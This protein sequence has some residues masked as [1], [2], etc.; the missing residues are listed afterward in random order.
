MGSK[1][2]LFVLAAVIT[3]VWPF[4]LVRSVWGPRPPPSMLLTPLRSLRSDSHSTKSPVASR[5]AR[6]GTRNLLE[7]R[8]WGRET[9]FKEET[10]RP[11]ALDCN[12]LISP[13]S[14]RKT[15]GGAGG[16]VGRE[17]AGVAGRR[18]AWVGD[19]PAGF[20]SPLAPRGCCL[21]SPPRGPAPSP[22]PPDQPGPGSSLGF[23]L[24]DNT[25]QAGA[26][27]LVYDEVLPHEKD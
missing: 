5:A 6:E 3:S 11:G 16:M 20:M 24:L 23:L 9:G 26:G 1:S 27:A 10:V 15:D 18:P 2:A 21:L 12:T 4:G 17:G 14:P 8:P 19:G 7:G 22:A 13:R 25:C